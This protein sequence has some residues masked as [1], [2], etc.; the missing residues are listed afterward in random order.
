MGPAQFRFHRVI[1][2]DTEDGEHLDFFIRKCPTLESSN[3]RGSTS[4]ST[5]ETDKLLK[6]VK[7][8]GRFVPFVWTEQK[9]ETAGGC[10]F[11]D[12]SLRRLGSRSNLVIEY[13]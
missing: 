1:G 10:I 4:L 5:P 6:A 13:G 12:S 9:L 7:E 3:S 8:Q 2:V 11:V